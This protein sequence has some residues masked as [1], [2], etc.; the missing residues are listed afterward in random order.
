MSIRYSTLDLLKCFA[1]VVVTAHWSAPSSANDLPTIPGPFPSS[2]GLT[3]PIIPC[4]SAC[5]W[6][7]LA[8]PLFVE[9]PLDTWLSEHQYCK[10]ADQVS[11]LADYILIA[12]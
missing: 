5:C 10:P 1:L 2:L 12:C 8:A 9:D 6:G 7:L 4:R 11:S 3:L